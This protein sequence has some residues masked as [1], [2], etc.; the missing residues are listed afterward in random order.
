MY[1]SPVHQALVVYNKAR[2]GNISP[3]DTA[4]GD[5]S[6][7]TVCIMRLVGSGGSASIKTLFKY[8][9]FEMARWGPSSG[10]KISP[11]G[12]KI[13]MQNNIAVSVCDSSGTNIK[14]IWV[15]SLNYDLFAQS[16]DDS[17][18][19][20]RIVYSIGTII[21]RSVINTDNTRGKTD[22]LW[23]MAW[24]KDP[25]VNVGTRSGY[26]SPNKIGNYLSF[27]IKTSGVWLPVVVNLSTQ[28]SVNP[29]NGGDGCV[30]RMADSFGTVCYN[31]ATHLTA[32]P[33]FRASTGA[34]LNSIPC[35]NGQTNTCSDCGLCSINFCMTDTNY[36][37]HCGDVDNNVS[38][39]CYSKA[40]I[41]KGKTAKSPQEIYLGDYIGFPD[42][43]IDPNP[44]VTTGM[45][46][47]RIAPRQNGRLSI[48]FTADG[49]TISDVD[50]KIIDNA[51]LTGINGAIAAV[52]WKTAANQ[53][54]FKVK[55][56]PS[57]IYILTWRSEKS[58]DKMLISTI[59]NRIR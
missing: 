46:E 9:Q 26:A 42:F 32:A 49:L 43:W 2:G 38:P 31:P 23:N 3:D 12:A 4:K 27:D 11:D 41:R 47:G 33:L 29:T 59:N 14:V 34:F 21:V 13:A 19:I 39:G 18:G 54:R 56:M 10:Y 53:W 45:G 20:R 50:G 30:M 16:W 1:G 8:V 55:S 15:G 36:F 5:K 57:G 28:T 58:P 25:S 17:A 6:L 37:I 51:V 52:G 48:K 7:D 22:T 40:F 35:G 24:N 44:F